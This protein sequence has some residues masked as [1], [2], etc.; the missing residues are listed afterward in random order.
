MN[1]TNTL[2]LP[3]INFKKITFKCGK[4]IHLGESDKII[5]IGP[6]NSGKSQT[7]RDIFAIAAQTSGFEKIV[8]ED[9]LI[10]KNIPRIQLENFLKEHA[11]YIHPNYHY[12]SWRLYEG[13]INQWD[14]K[15]LNGHLVDGFI[16]NIS[17]KERLEIC[18][19]QKS[20]SPNEPKTKPQHILYDDDQL[21]QK[22]SKLFYKAFN[23][24]LMFDFKGGSK[25][26]IHIGE[27]PKGDKFIDRQTNLYRD[28]VR[29]NPLLNMQGDGVKSY[30]GIL[31]ETLTSKH[32]MILLDEPEA[33]L[34]PPQM[35]KLGET[36]ASEVKGQMIVAT[37]SSDIMRGF[38]EGTKGNVRIIRIQKNDNGNL[39]H[40]ANSEAIKELWSKP[41]LRFSNALDGIFHEQIIICEDDSDCRLYNY[42]AEWLKNNNNHQLLDT[43][44]VPAGGKAAIHGIASVLRKV[45][46]PTKA[47]FD[48]DFLSD[49]KLIEDTVKAFGSDP[50]NILKEWGKVDS[51][52]RNGIKPKTIEE[53][54]KEIVEIISKSKP[55]ELKKSDIQDAM[56]QGQAWSI[57]KQ[58]GAAILPSGDATIAYENLICMLEETG[59]YIV[60][61]G[62]IERFNKKI[63][64]HGPKF[65]SKVLSEHSLD[66]KEFDDLKMFVEKVHKGP[67][68]ILDTTPINSDKVAVEMAENK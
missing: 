58:A 62:E 43:S 55:N 48:I 59:I 57:L 46:V 29:K 22:I 1:N 60:P 23:Q 68:S 44:Y 34:H 65:V 2:P 45:G 12:G 9:V 25:L 27:I 7:L 10:S 39:I 49:K 63:G 5:I 31:F 33:F 28:A 64:G 26:P 18:E 13:Y 15:Y 53:I 61:V 51:F 47:I 20:V 4:T 41:N 67:H 36:L 37:H 42:T 8:V 21:M 17:A 6:N 30:A 32:D 52:V 11:E 3:T 19:Q 50:T 40:E 66:E 56:K 16:K 14:G 54:K 35:R 24:E 38:L